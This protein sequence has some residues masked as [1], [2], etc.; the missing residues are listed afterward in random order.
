VI[1]KS[2]GCVWLAVPPISKRYFL[3]IIKHRNAPVPRARQYFS[4]SEASDF[5]FWSWS[6]FCGHGWGIS[7][8]LL[9]FVLNLFQVRIR[10]MAALYG[11]QKDEFVTSL[12]AL[13]LYDGDA[14]ISS[15]NIKTLLAATNNVTAPYW[16]ALFAGILKDNKIEKLVF[17]VGGGGGGAAPAAGGAAA[18]A[19]DAPKEEKKEKPKEEEVD[20]LDGGM[21]MFGGGGKGG[22]GDY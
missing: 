16:P 7:H 13:A 22:G 20:A 10:I 14:E 18:A 21:D 9:A 11:A 19:G 17:S 6:S 15:D 8:L 4:G 5:W 2:K 3:P 12:A 1:A